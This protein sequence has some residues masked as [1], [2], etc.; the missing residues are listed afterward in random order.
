MPTGLPD[1]TYRLRFYNNKEYKRLPMRVSL[2][3]HLVGAALPVPETKH[4]PSQ[5]EGAVKRIACEMPPIN[6][7][8]LRRFKRFVKKFLR[9]HFS[10]CQFSYE[11]TFDLEEYLIGTN[12]TMERKDQLRKAFAEAFEAHKHTQIANHSK[13]EPYPE[14]KH[15]RGINSRHDW[16][17]AFMGR[18]FQKIDKKIFSMKQFIKKIPIHRR[19]EWMSDKFQHARNIFNTDFSSFEATFGPLLMRIERMVYSFFLANNQHHDDFMRMYDM[20]INNI[21][22]IKGKDFLFEI[23]CRRMSGEM[24]TSSG[25]GIMNLLMTYFILQ[26][27]G[28]PLDL[29]SAFEGDDGQNAPD[30]VIPSSHHYAELGANIKIEIP[31]SPSESSFCGLIYDVVAKDNVT[32]PLECLMS[33]GWTSRQYADACPKKLK[34]L[35]RSKAMSLLYEYPACPVLKHLAA[36]ALRVTT[37]IDDDYL[38]NVDSKTWRSMYDKDQWKQMKENLKHTE[39]LSKPIHVNSRYLVQKKFGIPVTTQIKI[40]KYLDSLQTIQPLVIPELL[41]IAHRDTIDY[42]SNYVIEMPK[43]SSYTFHRTPQRKYQIW[44]EHRQVRDGR[45]NL[46]LSSIVDYIQ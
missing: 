27:L 46:V 35:L 24:N 38:S 42:Y 2:G 12:Y 15:F 10:D 22:R 1:S 44:W 14:Y 31:E 3:C 37:E 7:A 21:N 25:N 34:A 17:K 19:P 13:E 41:T 5:L 6:R 32:D 8:T 28:N 43:S 18:F 20:G 45:G 4:V 29:E 11:E 40:E 16:Y 9:T 23:M 26:E 30:L 39:F 33:F 36:Y